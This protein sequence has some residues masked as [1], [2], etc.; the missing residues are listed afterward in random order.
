MTGIFAGSKR[1]R[2]IHNSRIVDFHDQFAFPEEPFGK[3][4]E[5]TD[6]RRTTTHVSN[7]L[8]TIADEKRRPFH[9]TSLPA[10]F[11]NPSIRLSR[12]ESTT[13]AASASSPG[14]KIGHTEEKPVH[15]ANVQRQL[16][17]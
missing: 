6:W 5:S 3:G 7:H 15:R 4:T 16:T 13:P 17:E 8:F 10:V 14:H 11:N 9:N 2:F 1:M 12:Y